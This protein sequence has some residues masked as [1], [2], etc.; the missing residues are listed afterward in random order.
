[1]DKEI[2]LLKEKGVRIF[3][4]ITAHLNTEGSIYQANKSKD[5]FVKNREGKTY[6][7]DFGQFTTATV[8]LTNPEAFNWYKST[9][10]KVNGFDIA[11]FFFRLFKLMHISPW[12]HMS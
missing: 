3:A 7:M 10:P 1:M 9:K 12:L 8:D 2:K 4:Y 5:Y 11:L 6:L